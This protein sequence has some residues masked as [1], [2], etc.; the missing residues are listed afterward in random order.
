MNDNTA[1]DSSTAKSVSPNSLFL[2]VP[3]GIQGTFQGYENAG[4]SWSP[5]IDK[6]AVDLAKATEKFKVV[7]KDTENPF[8][9]SKYADLSQLIDATRVALLTYGLVVIQSPSVQEEKATVTTLL[10]H[11]SGQW[12]KSVISLPGK[13]KGKDGS[14]KFDAQTIG[15]AITYARRYAYQSILN[16]SA[17]VDDDGNAASS[18]VQSK[19]YQK[20]K[21]KPEFSSFSAAASSPD[22]SDLPPFAGSSGVPK[23]NLGGDFPTKEERTG[24]VN[25]LRYYMKTT[26]PKAGVQNADEVLQTYVKKF[27]GKDSTKDYTKTDWNTLLAALD[28]AKEQDKLAELVQQ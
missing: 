19:T 14:P 8:Y 4:F 7:S 15:S 2:G 11:N 6:L 23:A 20:Q 17:E 10:L 26:L 18:E 21:S 9:N 25:R 22:E 1:L 13:G 24:Y 28:A 12:I 16:I 5:Q 27:T 3:Q